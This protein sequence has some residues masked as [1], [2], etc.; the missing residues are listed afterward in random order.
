ME[1]PFRRTPDL[2]LGPGGEV[3]FT[4]AAWM[5]GS[6]VHSSE[7]GRQMRTFECNP[8]HT[9]TGR[10]VLAAGSTASAPAKQTVGT[11]ERYYRKAKNFYC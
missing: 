1:V 8:P 2:K 5:P 11:Q 4:D 7:E 3:P 6:Y 9:P 10:S